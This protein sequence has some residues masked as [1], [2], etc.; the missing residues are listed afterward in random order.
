MKERE[1]AATEKTIVNKGETS[2]ETV[3]RVSNVGRHPKPN[4]LV[5]NSSASKQ[6]CVGD[7]S[8]CGHVP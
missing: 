6:H 8:C 7:Y 1:I 5:A 3:I 2:E 4:K